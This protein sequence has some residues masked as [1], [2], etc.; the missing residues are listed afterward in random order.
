MPP[1]PNMVSPQ[2]RR[3]RTAAASPNR[4]AATPSRSM[5]LPPRVGTP[6]K[7]PRKLDNDIA[8]SSGGEG[9]QGEFVHSSAKEGFNRKM[10]LPLVVLLSFSVRNNVS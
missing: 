3:S 9:I 2:R 6:R 10:M 5:K 1:T 7:T 4:Q 8:V